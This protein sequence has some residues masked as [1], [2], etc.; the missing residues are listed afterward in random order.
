MGQYLAALYSQIYGL[1]LDVSLVEFCKPTSLCLTKIADACNKVHKIHEYVSASLLQ[2]NSLEACALSLE[3]SHLLENLKTRLFFIY[4]ALLD[5]PTYFSK[6]HSSVGL[7]DLHKKLNVQFYNEC[8]IEVNLTLI[9]DIERFLSR[10]NCVFYCLSS[11]SALLALK[12]A[13][14]FLGQLRGISPVPRTDIYITSSSCLEC[15][16]ETSVVPNQGETLNELL[17]NHNCHH[18]VERVPPEPIKGLFESELQNLGLKVH[19]A[20]DTIEQSVGKHEAVLQESLAYLKAHTIFNNTPKQVLELSNLLYWNSGQNQPSDSG[21]KCSELSKIWSRENELQKYRP[22]LNNGE[23]PG[24]FFDLHSPQGTELLFCGGIF[25]ST[26]DTITALKQ[27]CSNTFMKQTRLTG[28]AKRQNELFMRLSNILYGEEVPTK[29]KQTES[30]LKTCDQSDASKNQVLQEAELRKEAYLNKLSKEGFRKLQ[31]CLSTHEEM[32]NSQL[33]LK[34]WGS[35]VYKQSAT[36]L[37]HFLFRQSWVTQASLPPSVNGSPEQFENSKFIKSS[38]YVK[39]LS[40]EYLSTLRLHFFALIT[41]PLTTQEG[42][43]PSPPNVQLAHCLEA[44]HFMP[45][46]KMLLNEMIK[47]TM[48]PQDWICSNFNEFYTIHETDLNGVQYECWKYLRELVLS[49]ALYNITWEKNLCIYRTDHSCPTACSS[50]IKE[51][52]Y[53]TYESHAPLILVYSNKKWIF[54]DLYALLYA[55]MQLANNG[56]HR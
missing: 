40:R 2:Q 20:T 1:C 54:K 44:A 5:N 38:L 9:N 12:E 34:I 48:E 56:A 27:D 10:L 42:L 25:S 41:G 21:V 32:L 36:L 47:P 29:P 46:Q 22:K 43:F 8:G 37:N 19:I 26:H 52:L 23:P 4:H 31:A 51:G 24:H 7:C 35:V 33:S 49:V 17:L 13:L 28:V 14:T 30:A 50:G 18:L 3:L 53:V 15:V 16:L 55:H 45:H 39:S 6:L 11:S